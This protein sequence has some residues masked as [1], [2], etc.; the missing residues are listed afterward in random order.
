MHQDKFRVCFSND[1]WYTQSQFYTLLDQSGADQ[2]LIN[3]IKE[4]YN[5]KRNILKTQVNIILEQIK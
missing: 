2:P 5:N 3:Q 1:A 4:K